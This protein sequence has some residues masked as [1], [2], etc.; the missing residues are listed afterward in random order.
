MTYINYYTL[1]RFLQH[2]V[3][4]VDTAITMSNLA[5]STGRKKPRTKE[6]KLPAGSRRRSTLSHHLLASTVVG[7]DASAM[8]PTDVPYVCVGRFAVDF[9]QLCRR[10][11]LSYI[12]HVVAR[13][14][15]PA[16]ASVADE[17]RSTGFTAKPA[18]L[19]ALH[20]APDQS[21]AVD[22][23][24]G[25][26]P[27]PPPKTYVVRDSISFFRPSVQVFLP[28]IVSRKLVS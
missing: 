13:P 5:T 3:G 24:E 4:S 11:H 8:A 1:A 20:A 27:E 22:A 9:V 18:R 23:G 17:K 2:L 15:R 7:D 12:P 6:G 14:H 28:F 19:V 26:I 21:L 10:A 25:F 16:P